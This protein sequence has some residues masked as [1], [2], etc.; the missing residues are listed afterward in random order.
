MSIKEG[1][2]VTDVILER[3]PATLYLGV[4]AFV[5]SLLVGIPLGILSSIKRGKPH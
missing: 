2:P 4:T 5:V 1:R 3:T